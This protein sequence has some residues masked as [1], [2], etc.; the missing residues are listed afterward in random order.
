MSGRAG[1]PSLAAARTDSVSAWPSSGSRA[2]GPACSLPSIC[3]RTSERAWSSWQQT[4]LADP[5]LR[6]VAPDALH[7]TLVFLGYQAEKDVK[8]IAKAAFA[9]EAEAPAVELVAEPVGIPRGKRPR[10]IALARQLGGHRGAAGA[11]GGAPGG[12]R[13]PRA[14]EAGVLAARDGGAGQARGAEEP[15]ARAGHDPAR[16]RYPN[17]CSGSSVRL[18]W[19]SSGPT[20][21]GRARS[22][23][24][25]PSWSFRPPT[26]TR[27]LRGDRDGRSEAQPE[28]GRREGREGA[29]PG[30]AGGG[31]ADREGVRPGRAD[32]AR[33]P[34]RAQGGVRS[35]P[36][37]CRST[38]RWASAG[39]RAA[40]S[41]RSSDPS[42][43]ARPR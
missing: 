25:W 43:P 18:V 17:T 4:A 32:E 22:T 10:L 26:T 24:R 7:V 8:A 31:H 9:V 20:C 5:A 21:A 40:A 39:S 33:G 3:R 23:K 30:A 27:G 34:G 41:S 2:R 16:T 36:A 13:L 19:C 28:R 12:G 15:E 42:P 14:R 11:G 37:R 38:S 6:I 1:A 35:P 29:R